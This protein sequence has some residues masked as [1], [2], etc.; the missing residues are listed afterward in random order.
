MD[1]IIN[2]RQALASFG[3]LGLGAVLA[4]CGNGGGDD[5]A[6]T[7]AGAG[8]GPDTTAGPDAGATTA[9]DAAGS[10]AA[11]ATTSTTSADQAGAGSVTAS[12]FDDAAACTLTAEQTAGPFYFN[13]E[14]LRRDIR[15]DRQGS[16]LRLG[17]R[18]RDAATCAPLPGA[19]V[20]IWHCDALGLY[21]GFEATSTG[22]GGGGLGGGPTD[23]ETYLRGA[24]VADADG[25]VEFV[26]IYPGWYRGRTA[27]IHAKVH[28]D[29]STALTTQLYFDDEFTEAVYTTEPYASAGGRDTFNDNDGIF[30]EGLVLTLSEDGDGTLGLATFD[31]N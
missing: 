9:V 31:V 24:Q 22:A 4:A 6:A 25:I 26:T 18:V 5:A 7:T 8:A 20:D 30:D 29:N 11:G 15:E 27:H 2:R 16:R 14:S 23:S 3:T 17:I 12:M 10:S 1:R 19:V 28:L 13:V 21:S